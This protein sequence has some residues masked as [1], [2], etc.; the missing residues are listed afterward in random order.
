MTR[1]TRFYKAFM[2]WG[3]RFGVM[4]RTAPRTVSRAL[5]ALTLGLAFSMSP[6]GAGASSNGSSPAWMSEFLPIHFGGEVADPAN[7]PAGVRVITGALVPGQQPTGETPTALG[8]AVWFWEDYAGAPMG[9]LEWTIYF[10]VWL[11]AEDPEGKFLFSFVAPATYTV[12]ACDHHPDFLFV[13]RP[14]GYVGLRTWAHLEENV[15]G[16]WIIDPVTCTG[17][18]PPFVGQSWGAALR[19]GDAHFC[20]DLECQTIGGQVPGPF[21]GIFSIGQSIQLG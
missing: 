2:A 8:G 10:Q 18:P 3:A 11:D 7:P 12:A 4:N 16:Y 19:G 9:P 17:V 13:G 1:A 14:D 15:N 20:L 21:G 6:S 5:L